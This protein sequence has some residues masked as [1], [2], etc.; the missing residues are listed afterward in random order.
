MTS[1]D[2]R[3]TTRGE[4]LYAIVLGW[5]R[6]GKS[7]IHC[8]ATPAG[9]VST[10]SLLGHGGILDWRQTDEGLVVNLPAE[11]PCDHAVVFKITGVNMKPAPKAAA[12]GHEGSRTPDD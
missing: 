2:I 1:K 4:V 9:H 8:L 3:F 10:V 12:I 11:K 6:A 7:V 5:P